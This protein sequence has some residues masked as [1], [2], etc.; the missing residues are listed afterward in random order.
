MAR[1]AGR[2]WTRLPEGVS[3]FPLAVLLVAVVIIAVVSI[4]ENVLA[5]LVEVA[6]LTVGVWGSYVLG[7]Q[8]VP[9]GDARPH[10]RK[11]FRRMA[12]LYAQL[13]ALTE[14]I[15]SDVSEAK[16]RKGERAAERAVLAL[17]YTGFAVGQNLAVIADAMEDWAD[18]V[19]GEATE[20]RQG[21]SHEASLTSEQFR[22]DGPEPHEAIDEAQLIVVDEEALVVVEDAQEMNEED[23]Q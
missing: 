21:I 14:R 6:L 8:S 1:E 9:G 19:P 4:I 18:V 10:A 17:E 3:P 20:L 22:L 23:E 2:G 7:Q 11:A 15:A 12:T 16:A 13:F 5:G